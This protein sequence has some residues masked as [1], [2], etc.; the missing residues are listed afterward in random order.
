MSDKSS[1]ATANGCNHA[2][3]K[4][5][6]LLALCCL[7]ALCGFFVEAP[8]VA[9]DVG[10][11]PGFRD[12]RDC[13]EMV[14]IPAGSFQMGSTDAE[15]E[16]E[17]AKVPPPQSLIVSIIGGITGTTDLDKAE[18]FMAYEHPAHLVTIGKP[19]AIGKYSVTHGEFAAFVHETG[20]ITA[21]CIFF[22][23]LGHPV[24]PTRNAWE[25]P[26]FDQTDR[27]PV[28]CVSWN[29]AQAY[30][31]WLNSKVA[32]DKTIPSK[33]PYRLPTEA[34]WEYAARAGTRTSRYW[35]DDIGIGH[36]LCAVCGGRPV[37]CADTL[38]FRGKIPP[39]GVKCFIAPVNQT[40]PGDSFAPN[41]FGLFDMLGNAA[42]WT[43]DCWSPT[44]PSAPVV[45]DPTLRLNCPSRVQRGASWDTAA[46]V[47]RAATR[48]GLPVDS[49]TNLAGFRVA[50]TLN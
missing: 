45:D 27:D 25:H 6:G 21:P 7:V 39:A 24:A 49:A 32:V 38:Q 37:P 15:A 18:R 23:Y 4:Y 22:G 47:V 31:A 44:Y 43:Q 33:G 34:E 5:F 2:M 12:C 28:I 16:R 17:L 8:A 20:H 46:W 3:T 14:V 1:N 42:N 13:P 50:K 29:D 40:L 19:F 35:G 11:P 10:A 36:A 30:I 48:G 41:Q 26:H 9:Q